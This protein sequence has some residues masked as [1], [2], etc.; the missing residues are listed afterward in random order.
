MSLNEPHV[1]ATE[2]A[3]EH[4]LET[5]RS[6]YADAEGPNPNAVLWELLAAARPRTVLEVGP[7]PGALS[8]RIARE[9]GADVVAI[10]ISE[11]MVELARS[12]GVDARIGDVQSLPFPDGSF[13]VVVAAWVLYHVPDL[14]RGLAEIERVLVRGG[15][16]VAVTNSERHLEEA[17]SLAGTSMI[18]R[19][20][21]ARENGCDALRRHFPDVE[22]HDLD[23]TVVFPDA[24]AVRRYLRSTILLREA[25]DRVP[26]LDAPLRAG[27][28]NT[29]F[30]ATKSAA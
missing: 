8:A 30:V 2:Y 9:L 11:R 25:A 28:R 5:R 4:G 26:E 7:G 3:T 21:F 15:R 10:D 18:G 20:S 13:D 24:D 16:L 23:S 19:V 29:V 12:R 14:D 17:R 22:Q 1:V 27:S 6:L